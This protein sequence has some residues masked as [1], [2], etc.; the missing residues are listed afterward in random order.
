MSTI[1]RPRLVFAVFGLGAVLFVAGGLGLVGGPANRGSAAGTPPAPRDGSLTTTIANLQ[2]RLQRV[3]NDHLAW[4]TLGLAYVQQARVTAVPDYYAKAEGA[5]DKS[6]ALNTEDNY[7]GA[8]GRS[9]LASARHDFAQAR[10]WAEVGIA[11][12]PSNATLYGALDDALTQLGDY[13]GAQAATQRMV[14]LAPDTAS[15]SR[16][17][18]SW[19]LRGDVDLARRY[20]QRAREAATNPSDV[21][22]TERYLGDLDFNSGDPAAALGHYR[23]GLD[24]Y[25]D[26][27]FCLEGRAKAN[28]ALG[29]VDD[30]VRDYQALIERAPEP[31]FIL[32]F[33]EYLQS[34]GRDDEATK[35]Y[36]LFGVVVRLFEAAGVNADV[37]Q[38]LFAADHGDPAQ[39]LKYG[40]AGIG[41]RGFLEMQDAYAWALHVNGRDAEALQASES[42]R[43]LG[44]RNALLHFHAGMINRAL[45]NLDVARAELVTAL[46]INPH[47]SPLW[48]PQARQAVAEIDNAGR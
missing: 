25:A 3:P 27:T 17:S 7:V 32:A 1:R 44:T 15:L 20:M 33:G 12:N 9:S 40:T 48:A 43:A 28:A 2:T 38:T 18:Y 46:D 8:A 39:A 14:D 36:D 6:W 34:L 4:A 45:G 5:L 22:F 31:S 24:A 30:A 26:D 35:Q 41:S 47:F 19:E 10:H 37:D 42:A 21:A 29:N 23:A 16:V 13:Q 11:I